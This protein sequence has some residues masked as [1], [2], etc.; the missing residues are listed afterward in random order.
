LS[1]TLTQNILTQNLQPIRKFLGAP[2]S[3]PTKTN[4]RIDT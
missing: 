1:V 3:A 2:S 4:L